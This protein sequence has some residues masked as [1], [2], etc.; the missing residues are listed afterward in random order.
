MTNPVIR[1]VMSAVFCLVTVLL[2]LAPAL[3]GAAAVRQVTIAAAPVER[4]AMVVT[5]TLP[6]EFADGAILRDAANQVVPLQAEADLTAKF[7]VARQAAGQT[8]RFTLEPGRTPDQGNVQVVEEPSPPRPGN[9]PG[10]ATAAGASLIQGKA[11][12]LRVS[13]GGRPILYY[14][15][16]RD[17]VPR[18]DIDPKLR[19]AGYLHPVLTPLG[20]AVTEDYPADDPAQHG[21]TTVWRDLPFQ[22]R[23][24]DFG[25]PLR[26]PERIEFGGIDRTWNGPVNGGFASWHRWVESADPGGAVILNE[27]WELTAYALPPEL[28]GLNLFDLAVVQNEPANEFM[29]VSFDERGGLSVRT[30]ANWDRRVYGMDIRYPLFPPSPAPQ[31]AVDAFDFSSGPLPIAKPADG[32]RVDPAVFFSTSGLVGNAPTGLAIFHPS[33]IAPAFIWRLL[34]RNAPQLQERFSP[35]LRLAFRGGRNMEF[36]QR[37]VVFDGP[38]DNALLEA[39]WNGYTVPA[40]VSVTPAR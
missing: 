34:N 17:A 36:R 32:P 12:R 10:I 16:D 24:L 18:E 19:R 7:I 22:G 21:I 26:H 14:Q 1:K 29:V 15:M 8:L 11:G 5:L 38:P 33:E 25:D 13:V 9:T 37:I 6:R 31:G 30:P 23:V 39:L 35:S 4:A 20:H 27:N 3:R 28:K 40:V 2:A